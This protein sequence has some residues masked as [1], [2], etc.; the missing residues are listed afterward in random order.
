MTEH[1]IKMHAIFESEAEKWRVDCALLLAQIDF[2]TDA[3]GEDLGD[4]D[5]A[6]VEQIRADLTA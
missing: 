1:G 5:S 3:T 4:D 6:L 2:L